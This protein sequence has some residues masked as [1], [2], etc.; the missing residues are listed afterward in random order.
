MTYL[1]KNSKNCEKKIG[2]QAWQ[3]SVCLASLQCNL[4]YY[5]IPPSC[6]RKEKTHRNPHILNS[7]KPFFLYNFHSNIIIPKCC[8]IVSEVASCFC[9]G[10]LVVVSWRGHTVQY[11]S[12]APG[13][14]ALSCWAELCNGEGECLKQ[15]FC[16]FRS[17]TQHSAFDQ[18]TLMFFDLTHTLNVYTLMSYI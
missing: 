7:A 14:Q 10:W 5:C 1:V 17:M 2:L 16:F 12:Q 9:L 4:E 8:V 11:T 15:Y 6:V 3:C 18:N 13:A